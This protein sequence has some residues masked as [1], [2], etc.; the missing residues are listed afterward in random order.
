MREYIAVIGQGQN[1]GDPPLPEHVR[2][3][4]YEVGRHIAQ[5]G[6]VLVCGGLGGVME[7]ASQGAADAGGEIIAFLPGLDRRAANPYVTHAFPTGL[8]TLRNY[9][10]IRSADAAILIAGGVGTLQEATIAYDHR[11][12][13]VLLR[14]TGGWADRLPALLLEGRYLDERRKVAFALAST[15]EEAVAKARE[16]GRSPTPSP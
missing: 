6:A 7:A 8:G 9:L 16:R 2:R 3:A 4:A 13:V 5:A 14:G 10:I 1:P 12:P 15:P 11:V